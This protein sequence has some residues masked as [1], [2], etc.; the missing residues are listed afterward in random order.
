MDVHDFLI[1]RAAAADPG[2]TY[3]GIS[4]ADLLCMT[5][6]VPGRSRDMDASLI[7]FRP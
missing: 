5:S 2:P 1:L 7:C 3:T 6:A 4:A